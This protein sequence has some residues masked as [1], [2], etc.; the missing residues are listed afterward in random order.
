M[1]QCSNS[2]GDRMVCWGV[3][4]LPIHGVKKFFSFL[5]VIPNAK[6]PNLYKKW[7]FI[8]QPWLS[9]RGLPLARM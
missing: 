5:M 7:G 6:T 3:A 9:P 4:N 8:N 2:E 1:L